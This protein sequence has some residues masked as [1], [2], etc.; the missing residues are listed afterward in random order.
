[1]NPRPRPAL[2]FTR[3]VRDLIRAV[4]RGKVTS[5][6][7]IA[8]LACDARQARQVAWILHSSSEKDRLPWHR[9]IG[10][11]GRISLP[12]ARG[13]RE[14]R[15]LLEAEG[16]RFGP[17][18]RLDWSVYGWSPRRP[19]SRAFEDIDLSRLLD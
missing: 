13:G 18:G 2:D 15:R 3:R 12:P 14:Q 5:Y 10:A 6:G 8:A 16:V 11:A 7:R 9:V 1:V 4:P 19:R 17:G